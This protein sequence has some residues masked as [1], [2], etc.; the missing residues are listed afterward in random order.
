VMFEGFFVSTLLSFGG[1]MG[2]WPPASYSFL[3]GTGY[4]NE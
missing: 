4:F 1:L 2:E 3:F